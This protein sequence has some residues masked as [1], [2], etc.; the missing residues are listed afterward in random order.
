MDGAVELT[1]GFSPADE[2][3]AWARALKENVPWTQPV[4]RLFGRD[5]PSPRL[6]AWYGDP[7]AVYTYSGLCNE[8]LPWSGPLQTIRSRVEAA[9]GERFNSVLVN[10]YRDGRD[11]MGWHSDD[12]AE[13][14]PEAAIASVSLGETRR[15]RLQNKRIGHR[16]IEIPLTHGS[17]LIMRSPMQRLWRHSVPRESGVRGPRINLTF[18]SIR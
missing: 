4:V 3:Y 18:R 7:D 16:R 12:E 13:L 5:V 11:A 10:L 17:L 15:F 9:C 14:D 2:A 6:A 8:P 1:P